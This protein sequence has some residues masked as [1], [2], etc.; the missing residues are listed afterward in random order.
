MEKKMPL[1][2]SEVVVVDGGWEVHVHYEIRKVLHKRKGIPQQTFRDADAIALLE[3][4][5]FTKHQLITTNVIAGNSIRHPQRA[6]WKF[7]KIVDTPKKK[8]Y[9]RT[10]KK[11]VTPSLTKTEELCESTSHSPSSNSGQSVLGDTN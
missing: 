5:G 8:S 1:K 6:V 11:K 3:E 7:K 10:R 9:N 2:K 4:A